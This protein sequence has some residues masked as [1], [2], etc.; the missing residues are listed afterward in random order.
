MNTKMNTKTELAIESVLRLHPRDQVG[1]A[2]QEVRKGEPVTPSLS[3]VDSI[4]VGHK[5]ALE[6]VRAGEQVRKFGQSIG[7]AYEYI[8]AGTHVH[9]H[10]L[11]FNPDNTL[12]SVEPKAQEAPGTALSRVFNGIVRP[13]G[14]VATRNYIGVICS[15]NCSGNVARAIADSFRANETLDRHL[16]IDGVVALTHRTGCGIDSAGEAADVLRRTI[17]GYA[18]HPNFAGVLLVGLGC[19][20][21]Q[22]SHLMQRECLKE[23]S[24]LRT[25]IIQDSGGTGAAIRRGTEIVREML[26]AFANPV[27]EPVSASHLTL[28]LQCGGSD[29]FSALSANPALG[30][31]S[32]ILVRHGGTVVLSETPEIYG[33]EHLLLLRSRSPEVAA[34]LRERIEWWEEYAKV[35][36]G[37]LDNNPSP[38]NKLGGLTTI[39][40]KSLGAVCKAGASPLM[41]VYRYAEPITESGL[42]FM[43]A[44]GFDPV[45][46]TGQ[47]ASGANIMCFTT[48]RGSCFGAKPTPSLK[49]STN[50][51]LYKRMAG[52]IDINC[53][54]VLDG[55]CSLQAM[56]QVI[57]DRIISVASG[58]KTCSERLGYGEDEFA[59]WQL[60]GT[61]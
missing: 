24:R 7:E 18:R 47:I 26:V 50:T 27:R 23:S 5:V 48:G 21:N 29:G 11:R 36:G 51:P 40:E 60:G 6:C 59:P 56:G 43:D 4:P 39:L 55:D 8:P 14:R 57:F 20:A 41:Q 1:I 45:A 9:I 37:S 53:G 38:G 16:G 42:V 25:L 61:F 33:A 28:A 13:D 58:E 22:I 54:E 15:V 31:A 19:E 35:H 3:A 49:L 32:D 2:L 17:A 34:K 46:A 10:N 12:R 30:V 52:D 44:P